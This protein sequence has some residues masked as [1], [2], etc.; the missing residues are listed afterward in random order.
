MRLLQWTDPHWF[1]DGG[2]SIFQLLN[3]AGSNI[4]FGICCGDILPNCFDDALSFAIDNSLCVPGNH[5][6]ILKAGTN[7]DPYRWDL[8]PSQSAIYN[9]LLAPM[10]RK[11]QPTMQ[12]GK[13][14][15]FKDFKQFRI[16]GLNDCLNGKEAADEVTWLNSILDE[17]ISLNKKVILVSH[18]ANSSIFNRALDCSFTCDYY[19]FRSRWWPHHDSD[20]TYDA[21]KTL[22][23]AIKQKQQQGLE[24]VLQLCGHEHADGFFADPWPCLICGSTLAD[25]YNDCVRSANNVAAKYV[26]NLIELNDDSTID[27]YRLGSCNRTSGSYRKML[28]YDY[29]NKK[30]L[31]EVTD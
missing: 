31:T 6:S 15:W 26:A 21:L 2:Y 8:I 28:I 17:C 10:H 3:N 14:Y 23:P 7:Y 5:D 9:K 27:I 16:I 4:D 24:V 20:A 18:Y 30:V 11:L 1:S 29:K 13:T 19:F 22:Y 25:G 12:A